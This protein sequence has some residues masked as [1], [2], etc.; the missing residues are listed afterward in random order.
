[1][2]V[3][4]RWQKPPVSAPCTVLVTRAALVVI[5]LRYWFHKISKLLIVIP[6]AVGDADAKNP[7]VVRSTTGVPRKR[8]G[9]PTWRDLTSLYAPYPLLRAARTSALIVFIGYLCT[10]VCVLVQQ[11][12]FDLSRKRLARW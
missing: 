12:S 6:I 3:V 9:A 1:M 11:H 5:N 2:I 7:R 8:S 4:I 10:V